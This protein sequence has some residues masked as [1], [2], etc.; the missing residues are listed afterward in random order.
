MTVHS[1]N[2][3]FLVDITTREGMS[4][5]PVYA[6]EWTKAADEWEVKTTFLGLYSGRLREDAEVGIVWRAE[7]VNEIVDAAVAKLRR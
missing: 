7:V 2:R 5:S 6:R 3:Y 1:E 4:G